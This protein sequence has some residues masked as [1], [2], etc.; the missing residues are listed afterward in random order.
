M[1]Y[2]NTPETAVEAAASTDATGGEAPAAPRRRRATRAAT[3]PVPAEAAAAEPV[4]AEAAAEPADPTDEAAPAAP[5]R[6]RATRKVAEPAVAEPAV[7]EPTLVEAA[8]AEPVAAPARRR[9]A[10]SRPAAAPDAPI[11]PAADPVAAAPVAD[12]ESAG[13]GSAA[14]ETAA[15]A[16]KRSRSR[17]PKAAVVE[18]VVAPEPAADDELETDEDDATAD[19]AA[20]TTTSTTTSETP[21]GPRL[22]TTALLF[23][24]PDPS[25]GRARR[26]RVTSSAGSPEAISQ[27]ARAAAVESSSSAPQ[28]DEPGTAVA[29]A[30]KSRSTRSRGAKARGAE[31]RSVSADEGETFDAAVEQPRDEQASDE[32]TAD[33][34]IRD[35][36]QTRDGESGGSRRRGRRGRGG[37]R[38]RGTAEVTSD[39]SGDETAAVVDDET[40]DEPIDPTAD[41]TAASVDVDDDTQD[42]DESGEDGQAPR[43]RRRRGGRGRRRTEPGEAT[44]RDAGAQDATEDDESDEDDEGD[45]SG[46]AASS[47]RRRRR[48]RG[49]RSGDG[50]PAEEDRRRSPSDEVT[51]LRGST[52]LE[53]KRQRR[54]EGRDAGRRR[55]IISEAEFLARR[56]AVDRA[57]IVRE[58]GGRTQIAVL[59]DGVLV[60]HYVSNQAQASMVGNVY[61]GR[62]QNVLPSMEAAFV[63][64]GKGRNAVLY[65]GEV[66]WDAAGLEGGQPRRIEQALKSG[67]PVL[68]QVTKDPIGH[69]GARLTSQV[70]L[71]GRYLVYVPGGGMTGISRKLPDVERNRLKKILREVVPDSAGVIV[72][73]A[74]EGA[75]EEELR[76]DIARLQ[77]QWEAIEK[78]SKTASAPALLQGEPDMAIR[79]VRDI[80]N[81]DFGSLVVQGD[82]AWSTISSYIGDLAPD[83]AAKVSKYVGTGDVF[84]DHRIDEQLAKGMDRKVWLPSGGSL[85]ID[86]TEAMTVVDVNTGK[87]TGSGGTLEETVTR[88]NLEAAEEIVRQLRLRDIGG[89]IVIDFIDMVLESNRD[90]VLRRLVECLGRDRTKHQVAEVTSLGL[91][92]MT[93]KRVGQGLV[94]AFSETC[95]HCHGRGFVVHSEPIEKNVR[96]DAGVQQVEAPAGEAKRS[97][98]KRG[99]TTAAPA[100]VHPGVPVLPEE[101]SAVKATLATIAAAAAHAHE[102][103]DQ[104]AGVA[105]D[106]LAV[107]SDDVAADESLETVSDEVASDTATELVSDEAGSDETAQE[108]VSD[109]AGSDETESDEAVSDEA[110]SDDSEPD[111]PTL[112]VLAAFAS[113]RQPGAVD[114]LELT[115]VDPSVFVTFDEGEDERGD[116]GEQV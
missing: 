112:D 18:P 64:V 83:L 46:D 96:P 32:P 87:F 67:D 75:S 72:R 103:H 95:E 55:Q 28:D 35:G 39:E 2:E 44:S 25:L 116:Q 8:A 110:A 102:L 41:V 78:K 10:A 56:E 105:V 108:F 61:L 15:P 53:A 12:G 84:A 30:A 4:V 85:V 62:V 22:A 31:A 104:H 66:N 17:K 14:E 93:R 71:A 45:E 48:R 86:R 99:G 9:R 27:A 76:A 42:D 88:N 36:E 34:L 81:D 59:E 60:E 3:T 7:A 21:D 111:A 97:R 82:E 109:E 40:A 16:P 58:K 68:V 65:A 106:D 47:R 98:R 37:Q 90:L 73:T 11:E 80:F 115:P 92:Q 113:I 63:D 107:A 91:V 79:V 1:T 54:R 51:A 33:E 19:A 29:P 23:Q 70:T 94:E 114:T 77:G 49:A 52:R 57:M 38:S 13:D 6:R 89:I 20:T 5:K 69:K 43:R 101:R 74:A 100:A 26:R 24:A 50:R